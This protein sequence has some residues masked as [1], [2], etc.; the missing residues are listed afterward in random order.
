MGAEAC[1]AG[2]DSSI[3]QY[4]CGEDACR[5]MQKYIERFGVYT[6]TMR[7][8][9]CVC[10]FGDTLSFAFTSRYDSTNIQRNFYR[11]LKEQGI[12][13]KKVEADYPKEAKTNY[14]G[15]KV[16]QIFNFCCIA[17]VFVIMLNLILTPDLHWWI[18]AVAG[19]FS[20]WL[21]FATGYLKRY[22]LPRMRCGVRLL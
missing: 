12:F 13:V 8:E 3:V 2:S 20:M 22:N 10:S 9:L 4:E 15:K 18:F 17:K 6:S 7:T 14:E 21:A 19:G 5:N 11:I 16:F 1:R